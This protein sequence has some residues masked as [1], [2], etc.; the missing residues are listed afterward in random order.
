MN[1]PNRFRLTP[2]LRGSL[3][4]LAAAGL[5]ACG[6]GSGGGGAPQPTAGSP[7]GDTAPATPAANGTPTTGAVGKLAGT[8]AVGAPIVDG[9][10]TVRDADGQ[11]VAADV[12]IGP[13]GRYANVDL[14]GRGPWRLQACGQAGGQWT[15]LGSLVT[16]PGTGNVTPLTD[17]MVALGGVDPDGVARTQ[18]TLRTALAPMMTDAGLRSDFDFVT[19]ELVAGSRTG[20]DRLLDG[21]GVSSGE[22]DAPF[23]QITP[24]LG[25][26][27]LYLRANAAPE[28]ELRLDPGARIT[29]L[30]GLDALFRRLSDAIASPQACADPATGLAASLAS[31]ARLTR[32]DGS[33]VV[34]PAE[35]AAALC[36]TL[37][38][39]AGEAASWGSTLLPPVLGRCEFDRPV[40][41]CR[42]SFA[43]RAP[44]GTVRG[45]GEG[46]AVAFEGGQWRFLGELDPL[47]IRASARVQRDRRVDGPR[48]VDTY[49]RGL[50]FE[51]PA[52]TG[53]A[54]ARVSQRDAAGTL[55][56]VALYKR[57]GSGA[58]A[59][60][61]PHRLSLWTRD[62]RSGQP[63]LDAAAGATRAADDIGLILPD[64]PAGDA[65]VRNFHRAGRTVVVDLYSDAACAT[66]A[67]IDGRSRIEVEVTGIPPV[68]GAMPTLPWPELS[69]A[70][71]AALRGV[72]APT[73]PGAGGPTTP[74][75][76]TTP[77]TAGPTPPSA[78]GP[79]PPVAGVPTPPVTGGPTAPG[80]GGATPPVTGV[81]T[82]PVAGGATPPVTGVPT[83]PV[84][85]GA[86]PPVA[87]GPTPPGAGGP[88]P[89]S[90]GGPTPPVTGGPPSA[91]TGTAPTPGASGPTPPTAGGPTPPGAVTGSG[92]GPAGAPGLSWT[93]PRGPI[94]ID[95]AVVCMALECAVGSPER[96]AAAQLRPGATSA[97]L[98]P[99]S[100]ASGAPAVRVLSLKGRLRDGA[101]L[102]ANFMACPTR[103]IGQPCQ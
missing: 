55:S 11:T 53:L 54:C 26:G 22:D 25:G 76:P 49:G 31:Q 23:V 57:H 48:A 85:G 16:A 24:R 27:N 15:C 32:E 84:A 21:I 41:V 70:T 56:T 101:A 51:I 7:A 65:V 45:A 63:S 92:P 42:V 47:P 18:G 13:D 50:E 40:P 87:G 97:A 30:V 2:A 35:V 94:G 17:A 59:G 98:P 66:A 34:G 61:A 78:G 62:P 91:G 67:S 93:F 52:R 79:T 80:A 90:A 95:Q 12:P 100:A 44:D 96:M 60:A 75:Q 102:K 38:G 73:V 37:E 99:P 10:L 64:G 74:G 69:E 20:Y 82:P 77:G 1:P 4:A 5:A 8:V 103:P 3:L 71:L 28:G 19:G 14:S 83:P 89:P 86:T 39:G 68:W 58:G 72:T 33:T 6:G 9:T 36:A 43:L 46:M 81:P 29:P 88:T